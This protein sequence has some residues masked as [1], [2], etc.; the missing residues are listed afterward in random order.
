MIEL[1][2]R[3]EL[4]LYSY[5]N[6][7]MFFFSA[8]AFI[9]AVIKIWMS[10]SKSI[11]DKA[12]LNQ[13]QEFQGGYFDVGEKRHDQYLEIHRQTL[14]MYVELKTAYVEQENKALNAEIARLHKTPV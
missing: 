1:L 8:T 3:A 7:A 5:R 13:R 6:I 14:N 4:I 11:G 10:I 9:W 12:N 2:D